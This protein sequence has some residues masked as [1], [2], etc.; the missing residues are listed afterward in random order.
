M[1]TDAGKRY[2]LDHIATEAL[3]KMERTPDACRQL[4][5]RSGVLDEV[6]ADAVRRLAESEH[7]PPL[8]V[9]IDAINAIDAQ[10][11]RADTSVVFDLVR[12]LTGRSAAELSAARAELEKLATTSRQ[13]ILRQIGF[14][15]LV[16]VDHGADKAWQLATRST[17]ALTDFVDAMPLVADGN[18]QAAI[19][20]RIAPLVEGLPPGLAAKSNPR[21]VDGR[22][23]RIELPKRGTLTLAE[24]E[25]ISGGQNIARRGKASQKNTAHGGEAS[26]AID[27][28]KSGDFGSGGQTHTEENTANPWWEVDLG[29]EA[30]IESVIVINRN[31]GYLGKRLQGFTL[32]VLDRARKEVFRREKIPAPAGSMTIEV[33]DDDPATAVRHAAML[34]L[35]HVRGRE[36]ATFRSLA[37]F[38]GVA[39]DRATAV[40]ALG[41]LPRADW[42]KDEARPILES[43]VKYL[44]SVPVSERTNRE[45]V[46][47]L[48]FAHALTRLLPPSDA[49]RFRGELDELGVRVIRIGTLFERMSYD[50]ETIA[51]RAGRPVEFIFENTDLMPHN[52]V[53]AKAGAL[54]ELGL[55]SEATAQQPDAAR[56]QYVPVSDKVL[57][58]SSLLQPRTSEKL[59]FTAPTKPGVYPYVCTYPGHWRRMYGALYVVDDLDAYLENPEGYLASHPLEVK[60]ALLKDRRPRTEWKFDDLAAAV[61]TLKDGRSLSG[62]KQMFQ[63]ASCVAC[64]KLNGAGNAIGPDLTKLDAKLGPLDILKELLDPSAQINEKYQSFVFELDNGKVVT[65]LVIEETPDKVRV[66]ENPLAKSD[67]LELKP[68]EIAERT[69]SKTSIMP[70]GLLDKLSREE[71][72]D[73]IA[74]VIA[75]GNEHD[76]LFEGG[77]DHAGHH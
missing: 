12:Q 44:A 36:A 57:L 77:H 62:A 66:V 8:A 29:S 5:A 23:V 3:V 73:L 56:R 47:A 70:K 59:S 26:R 52:F 60:D 13:P 39:G 68:G 9:V 63:V 18:L 61:G 64:H 65:G 48:E 74:Y 25:V 50:K 71:I 28:N 51:V 35:T 43:V 6:R 41:S 37:P 76:K 10:H 30:P 54:E 38:V 20:D 55:A 17:G 27:G 19:A 33:S 22:Y 7:E 16:G 67:V 75:R 24:V 1:T 53:I 46:D 14:A 32:S 40:R 2:L 11:D 4:F 45:A 58:A 42:P 69:K 15:S 31:E 21:V 49:R 34:A 72:L